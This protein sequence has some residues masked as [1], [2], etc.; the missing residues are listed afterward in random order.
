MIKPSNCE[1]RF[2]IDL[3]TCDSMKLNTG[4]VIIVKKL[5]VRI[6]DTYKLYKKGTSYGI[7]GDL[8]ILS[9]INGSGKSQLL[10]IIAK[11]SKE[12]ISRN[13]VQIQN[14]GES[15]N[16]EDI[17]LLSFR[18]NINLGEDFGQFSV[19][20]KKNYATNPSINGT[21][22]LK[23]H[24]KSCMKNRHNNETYATQVKSQTSSFGGNFS[25][26]FGSKTQIAGPLKLGS[27]NIL[28]A[29]LKSKIVK[30]NLP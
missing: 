20:Y 17:L 4:M 3:I 19:T 12:S 25:P 10:Q 2:Y 29:S 16:I 9:G 14:N 13:V 1:E 6:L 5:A 11:N 7:D 18:D 21:T 28:L 22:T 15:E 30:Y 8:I 27:A 24:M 23:N 26:S